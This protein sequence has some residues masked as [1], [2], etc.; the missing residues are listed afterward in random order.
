MN[1][2]E[3]NRTITV[4]EVNPNLTKWD[5]K[6]E[7][8]RGYDKYGVYDTIKLNEG[9]WSI[10]STDK[11]MTEELAET[12]VP[13]VKGLVGYLNYSDEEDISTDTALESYKSFM[14]ANGYTVKDKQY[15]I[16]VKD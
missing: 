16:L 14:Q 6:Y 12:I 5:I 8:L 11:G 3:L 15:L 10:L 7:Y 9:N 2:H 4:V 1:Q 13:Y